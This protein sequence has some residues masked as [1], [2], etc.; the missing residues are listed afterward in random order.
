RP[1]IS[2]LFPYTTLFRSTESIDDGA[3]SRAFNTTDDDQSLQ[4]FGLRAPL[5]HEQALT[6]EYL[7]LLVGFLID[8]VPQCHSFKHGLRLRPLDRKSTRL[9]S[10]HVKIS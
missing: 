6:Q 8:L 3:L 7:V 9:N 2:T 5:S 4:F 1:P 10:S